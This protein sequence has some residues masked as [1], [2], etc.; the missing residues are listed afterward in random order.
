M[1]NGHDDALAFEKKALSRLVFNVMLFVDGDR[2]QH[3]IISCIS[4]ACP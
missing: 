3:S 2:K 1:S 4:V